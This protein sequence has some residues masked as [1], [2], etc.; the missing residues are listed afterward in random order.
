MLLGGLVTG[1][2][3]GPSGAAPVPHSTSVPARPPVAPITDVV[4]QTDPQT[5]VRAQIKLDEKEWG[6]A[7][8]VKVDGAPPGVSCH[9]YAVAKD[10]SRDAAAGW[11]IEA[12]E[13]GDF[14]GSTMIS[15]DRLASFEVVTTD[16][17]TLVT[18]PVPP[19]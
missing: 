2:A 11:R 5:H 16:G 7:L 17:H 3:G 9:L 15:R 18:I 13:Y 4:T 19:L 1:R 10:G 14:Y 12:Q 6:T 8:T